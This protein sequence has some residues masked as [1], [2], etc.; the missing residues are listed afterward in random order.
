MKGEGKERQWAI[1]RL[2]TPVGVLT[3]RNNMNVNSF[4]SRVKGW[5][6]KLNFL[7]VAFN[8]FIKRL[9]ILCVLVVASVS[10]NAQTKVLSLNQCIDTA[11]KNNLELK[12]SELQ[13]EN[14]RIDW[15]QAKANIL[16][17]INGNANHGVNQGR[18]IDPFTN[19]FV[20]QKINFAAYGVNGGITLFNGFG[21]Q[22][23]IRQYSYAYDASKMD[24]QQMKDNLTLNIILAYLQ[25]MTN[26]DLLTQSKNQLEVSKQQVGRLQKMNEQ[27]AIIPS[28]LSNLQGEAAGN[29][30]TMINNQNAL[31]S[32]KLDLF[33][34]M[35]VMFDP[36]ITFQRINTDA[37]NLQY[38]AGVAEIYQT[39]IEKLAL[40]KAANLRKLSAAKAV[41]A[42]K[43]Y[44]Y[45]SL[46][47][48][49]NVN[50]NYS[51]AAMLNTFLNTT[52][53]TS[54]NYV[55]INGIKTNVVT[56]QDNFKS[57]KINYNNQL[58]N[59]LY[60]TLSIDLRIPLLNS[61]TA[62]NRVK[63]AALDLKNSDYVAESTKVRLRQAVEQAFANMTAAR[64]RY[65]ALLRQVEAFTTSFRT[66]EVRFN[67]GVETVV[68]YI[69]SKNNLDRANSNLINA[70]YDYLL[71]TKVLDY[72]RGRP[73]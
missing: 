46:S 33:Q 50:T 72:Y 45:P 57:N 14:A 3:S 5:V 29:E 31:E 42:A 64:N 61:F 53:V 2:N 60:T 48:N 68:D 67:A 39:A 40:V 36:S 24:V 13:S 63:R 8:L 4:L 26:E 54:P 20:D 19:G 38:D 22:N 69:I 70:R 37:F 1:G 41:Q 49:G 12:Q 65:D 9:G 15:Q 71:R 6:K 43:G 32:S 21:I 25:V 23:T 47:F 52:E 44:L 35:N 16:P 51:S 56:M 11:F 28:L 59:N 66:S 73:L 17:S 7:K 30:L 62:R 58:N 34:L 10:M 18:S 55:L 27:G